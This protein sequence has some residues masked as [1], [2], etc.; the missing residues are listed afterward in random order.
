M[1]RGAV[2]YVLTAAFA[3]FSFW[4]WFFLSPGTLRFLETTQIFPYTISHLVNAFG[5]P[6]GIAEYI[7]EFC[8]QFFHIPFLGALFAAAGFCL[9]Q[10]LTWKTVESIRPGNE[11]LYSLSFVP[12]FCAWAFLCVL[13]SM[14]AAIVALVLVLG[15][16]VLH[17]H[18]VRDVWW[19]IAM[20]TALLY[21]VAGPVSILFPFFLILKAV[22]DR[23]FHQFLAALSG[24]LTWG[25]LPLLWGCFIQYTYIEL[26]RGIGYLNTPG[27]YTATFYLLVASVVAVPLVA[28]VF[29]RIKF[30]K[31]MSRVVF[32]GVSALVFGGGWLLVTH[33][34]NPMLERIYEY[35]GLCC[36]RNWDGVLK[37]AS[38]RQ[39]R[40]LSEISAVNLALAKKGTLLENMFNYPQPGPAA[41][42]PDYAV[43]YVITLTA[44]E[45]VYHSGML[46]VARHYAFEEYESYPNYKPSARHMKRLAEIDLIS[47]NQRTA[48]KYLKELE[49]TLFY[50][51]WAKKWLASPASL[52]ENPEYARLMTC[53][54]TSRYLYNHSS[55]QDKRLMLRRLVDKGVEYHVPS[56]YLIAYDLLAKDLRSLIEDLT[57]VKFDGAV[58][59]HV[60]EAACLLATFDL[61]CPPE[62]LALASWETQDSF[63]SFQRALIENQPPAMLKSVY[64]KTYWYWFS[65][66]K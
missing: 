10:I 7:S 65:S 23:D 31:V 40:T 41:L 49:N 37:K 2:K 52:P 18:H 51:S 12:G 62:I 15:H 56:D 29:P 58:P 50:G 45:A 59:K 8:V 42:F 66:R 4:F 16:F 35:D 5:Y 43:G 6:G 36:D 54:D 27:E 26:Y 28:S 33:N 20:E 38:E 39:P 14:F 55:D 22:S 19:K 11:V 17:V 21:C 1:N 34:C 60:Q 63:N 30:G 61:G 46:N 53:R 24:C 13:G 9:L 57:L 48:R 47:G 25:L 64:G 32:A 44:G 3:V